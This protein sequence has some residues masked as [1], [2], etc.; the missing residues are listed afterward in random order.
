MTQSRTGEGTKN[1][2][3]DIFTRTEIESHTGHLPTLVNTSEK[4]ADPYQRTLAY[5]NAGQNTASTLGDLAWERAYDELGNLT[6]AADPARPETTNS[7]D[8]RG[9]VTTTKLP[10][11][12]EQRYQWD[13][14]GALKSFTDPDSE[15]TGAVTDLLGRPLSR[16]YP[17][18]TV[19]T[20]EYEGGRIKSVT[21]S[22]GRPVALE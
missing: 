7:Y 12:A 22:D 21:R 4:G 15:T 13:A 19:E 16:T 5:N 2:I 17:D 10:G 1:L 11:D 6:A 3:S 20:I 14:S 8:S 18:G 9:V